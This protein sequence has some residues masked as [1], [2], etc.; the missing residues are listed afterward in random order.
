M[1]RNVVSF[2]SLDDVPLVPAHL[3][4]T[5]LI[6]LSTQLTKKA[7]RPNIPLCARSNG[8]TVLKRRHCS[9]L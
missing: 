6:N 5:P 3:L 9:G 2:Q 4:N 7:I 8:N 1:L